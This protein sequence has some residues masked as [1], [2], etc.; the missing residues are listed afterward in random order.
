MLARRGW[1]WTA[2]LALCAFVAGCS[3][4]FWPDI[5]LSALPPEQAEALTAAITGDD[6]DACF[7]AVTA[8][9]VQATSVPDRRNDR[10]CGY[11]G[12]VRVSATTLA[13]NNAFVAE[14][15]V[16]AALAAWEIGV[17]RP[18]ADARFA[19]QPAGLDHLGTYNCRSVNNRPGARLSQHAH[20]NAIDVAAIRLDDGRRI[21]VNADNWR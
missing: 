17:V 16:V 12:A 9:G 19:A 6:F 10:G 18:A 8:V 14:C 20:G 15:R 1:R 4:V 7:A 13:L 3:R 21:A 5:D 2:A 11:D